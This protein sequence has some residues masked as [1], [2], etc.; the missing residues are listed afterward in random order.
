MV[1]WFGFGVQGDGVAGARHIL[2]D[3]H[4][5]RAVRHGC[6]CEDAHGLSGLDAPLKPVPGGGQ[7][8]AQLAVV[9]DLAIDHG[10]DG[11]VRIGHRL[12]PGVGKIDDPPAVVTKTTP[13]PVHT[14]VPSRPPWARRAIIL[15]RAK[16][17]SVTYKFHDPQCA[18]LEAALGRGERRIG[19]VIRRAYEAGAQ[20]DAWGEHFSFERWQR[21][22]EAEGLSLEECATR[23]RD[24]TAP[25][26]WDHIDFALKKD[27]LLA[28][29]DKA[30]RTE[31]TPDCRTGECTVCGVCAVL[32]SSRSL[33]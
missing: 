18:L 7:I 33:A 30:F 11:A 16:L 23:P 12:A 8:V 4:A 5:I 27:F 20:F 15:D 3:D 24:T 22:F 14:A 29:R 6:S 9:I 32:F 10:M 19:R 1:G 31:M 25:L 17:R 2:L 21:A 26:P 28:E 13:S